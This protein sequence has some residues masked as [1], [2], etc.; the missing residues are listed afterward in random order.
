MSKVAFAKSAKSFEEQRQLLVERGLTV[1]EEESALHALSHIN[2]YRLSAYWI[3]LLTSRG[4]NAFQE[5]VTFD[6]ILNLYIFDREL[7]LLVIDAIERIE[8]S[9]RTQWAHQLSLKY[10]PHAYF[11]DS[12]GIRKKDYWLRDNIADLKAHLGRSDELFIGHF[13]NTYEEELPPAWVSC[14]VMS[15]GLL[16]R[17][18][19]NLNA[20]PARTAIANAYGLNESVLEGVMEHLTYIRNL[21]AHHS[22]LWNRRL[23]KLMPLP[24]TKPTGLREDMTDGTD[25]KIYNSM[26]MMA[27]LMD[28]ICIDHHWKQRLKDLITEHNIDTSKM[29]F[30]ADWQ[31][32]SIWQ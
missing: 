7:R 28:V 23:T 22:R 10:G 4:E 2:Y 25:R 16:S 32:K 29:G 1:N 27:Y 30:P 13:K 19:S 9:F 8:I 14:E 18:Y 31:A 5:G 26:V 11:V 24:R 20:Y 12:R 3:P 6:D 15:L 21:C 17:W